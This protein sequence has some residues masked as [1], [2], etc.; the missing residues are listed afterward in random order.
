MHLSLSFPFLILLCQGN[1][2]PPSVAVSWF[3]EVILK[4]FKSRLQVNAFNITHVEI[5]SSFVYTP[6][7]TPVRWCHGPCPLCSVFSISIAQNCANT[8]RLKYQF[9]TQL[10]GPLA[11]PVG[12]VVCDPRLYFEISFLSTRHCLIFK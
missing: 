11:F 2:K 3:Y 8:G 1:M 5:S 9:I 4:L 10:V 7:P 12:C 6:T